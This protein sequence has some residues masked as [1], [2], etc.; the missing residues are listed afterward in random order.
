MITAADD[1][2]TWITHSCDCDHWV[3]V[4][5]ERIVHV[6][7]GWFVE[8][9]EQFVVNLC[10]TSRSAYNMNDVIIVIIAGIIILHIAL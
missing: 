8:H 10:H 2:V 4:E 6:Y 9:N 3:L 5:C 1:D 7:V